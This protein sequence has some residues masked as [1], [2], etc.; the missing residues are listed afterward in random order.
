MGNKAIEIMAKVTN[1]GL[2]EEAMKKIIQYGSNAKI[3]ELSMKEINEL[4]EKIAKENGLM[5][6][7]AAPDKNGK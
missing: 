1:D 7:Q 6:F 3:E 4:L 5:G 2:S